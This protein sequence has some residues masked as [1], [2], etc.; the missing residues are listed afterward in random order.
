MRPPAL[1]PIFIQFALPRVANLFA[2][3]LNSRG[4]STHVLDNEAPPPTT[5]RMITES[6]YFQGL[7]ANVQAESLVVGERD[8]VRRLST[9]YL[10]TPLTEAKVERAL[11][12]FLSTERTE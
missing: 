5:G 3:L 2:L 9:L 7:N 6:Y 12:A 10:D 11:G 8:E 4:I 1:E